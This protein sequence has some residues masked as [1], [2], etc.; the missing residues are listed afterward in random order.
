MKN[1]RKRINDKKFGVQR[2]VNWFYVK[3][4]TVGWK[5]LMHCYCHG[6]KM[7]FLPTIH[8]KFCQIK[9]YQILKINNLT[10]FKIAKMSLG[11]NVRPSPPTPNFLNLS[12]FQEFSKSLRTTL[13]ASTFFSEISPN[14]LEIHIRQ[15][16]KTR[17]R[18]GLA[19]NK[20]LKNSLR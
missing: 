7:F 18:I 4:Q 19:V 9:N 5:Y 10:I 20:F 3:L 12:I 2:I 8:L 17:Q 6:P 1:W 15:L 11:E 13:I 16:E 14:F